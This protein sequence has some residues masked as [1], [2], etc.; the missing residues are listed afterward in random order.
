M[1]DIVTLPH[2]N[3]AYGDLPPATSV[4]TDPDENTINAWNQRLQI[5]I[6]TFFRWFYG[7]IMD[8]SAKISGKYEQEGGGFTKTAISLDKVGVIENIPQLISLENATGYTEGPDRSYL[9]P[10]LAPDGT[11]TLQIDPAYKNDRDPL[12]RQDYTAATR[13]RYHLVNLFGFSGGHRINQRKYTAYFN[14]KYRVK[15]FL[16]TR[17]SNNPIITWSDAPPN[18]SSISIT[19]ENYNNGGFDYYANFT[20]TEQLTQ[21][22][23]IYWYNV[24]NTQDNVELSLGFTYRNKDGVIRPFIETFGPPAAV[25]IDGYSLSKEIN[26]YPFKIATLWTSQKDRDL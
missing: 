8:C 9:V 21:T 15:K 17:S 11:T 10:T 18:A 7:S 3:F 25:S 6:T 1:T 26:D 23:I 22:L 13:Q 14:A 19:A 24:L 2:G 20:Q 12:I 16:E 4:Y 5:N